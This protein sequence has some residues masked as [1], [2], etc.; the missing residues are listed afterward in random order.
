MGKVHFQRTDDCR[1]VYKYCA[2]GYGYEV[3]RDNST[4]KVLLVTSKALKPGKFFGADP[5][6]RTRD[7]MR[8]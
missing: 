7:P 4:G 2:D 6:K 3:K 5:G 8:A 1:H